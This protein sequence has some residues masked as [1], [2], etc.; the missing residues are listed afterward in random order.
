MS[1]LPEKQRGKS[2]HGSSPSGSG[3]DVSGSTGH[4]DR[5]FPVLPPGLANHFGSNMANGLCA[6]NEVCNIHSGIETVEV[7]V[8]GQD[9]WT[10]EHCIQLCVYRMSTVW[11]PMRH[12]T[13]N[14][15]KFEYVV[16]VTRERPTDGTNTCKDDA[17]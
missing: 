12:G 9:D 7:R 13:N 14:L 6:T 8:R 11:F 3:E 17:R 4:T 5:Y 1:K 2:T 15:F 10:L 16:T